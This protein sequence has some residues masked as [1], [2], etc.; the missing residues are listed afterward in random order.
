MIGFARAIPRMPMKRQ[1]SPRATGR[2]AVYAIGVLFAACFVALLILWRAATNIGRSADLDQSTT[3][4]SGGSRRAPPPE[5]DGM[6]A[7]GLPGPFADSGTQLH[8][9][10]PRYPR[11][12]PGVVRCGQSMCR[13]S[14]ANQEVCCEGEFGARCQSASQPCPKFAWIHHCDETS[15]C[16]PGERCCVEKRVA[17]CTV[18]ECR[19]ER[20]QLCS[21]DDECSSGKCRRGAACAPTKSGRIKLPGGLPD[22]GARSPR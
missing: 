7:V 13:T 22:S 11:S 3:S 6:T 16:A 12:G 17:S 4:F 19:V 10:E 9:V 14:E 21:S 8:G 1:Q 2:R 5:R 15:D 18:G 20:H